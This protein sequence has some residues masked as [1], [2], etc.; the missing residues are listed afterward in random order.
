MEYS[1]QSLVEH[2][3]HYLCGNRFAADDYFIE[4]VKLKAK[5]QVLITDT[6]VRNALLRYSPCRTVEDVLNMSP[7]QCERIRGLGRKGRVQLVAELSFHGFDARHLLQK[8]D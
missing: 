8:G 5:I 6:R 1:A 7:S 2:A 4:Q 3:K